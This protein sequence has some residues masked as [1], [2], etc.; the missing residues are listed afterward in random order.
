MKIDNL[1]NNPE[2]DKFK[3]M[4]DIK[5]GKE[6]ITKLL[7]GLKVDKAAGP[8]LIKPILLNELHQELAP[9]LQ[10]LF[11]LSLDTGKL[12]SDWLDS[13]PVKEEKGEEMYYD[14][15]AVFSPRQSR[16]G[17]YD[18]LVMSSGVFPDTDSG[19]SSSYKSKL[20]SS[21]DFTQSPQISPGALVRS[22]SL[23]RLNAPFV[24]QEM[25]PFQTTFRMD[26]SI[27]NL[28][29]NLEDS[30][31]RRCVLM[32]KLKEA[33]DTLELQSERLSKIETAAKG[34]TI[35]VEDLRLKER[36]YRRKIDALHLT[37]QE[38]EMLKME[39][40]K[41][42][43]DMQDRIDKLDFALRS[44]QAQHQVTENE[45]QKRIVLLEQTGQALSMLENENT[46]LQQDRESMRQ[47]MAVAKEAIT[48]ARSKF[49][50]MEEENKDLR[51]QVMRL[52]EENAELTK[53]VAELSGQ[54]ME[55]RK[56]TSSMKD[57]N[58]KLAS[59]WK[60]LAEEKQKMSRQL[61]ASQEKASDLKS[62]AS[63]AAVE[64]DRLFHEK[65]DLN[66]KYQ[67]LLVTKEQL[68]RKSCVLE[69]QMRDAE[70]ELTRAKQVSQKR[71]EEK[72]RIEEEVHDL[73]KA[74]QDLSSEL[75]SVKAYYE[76]ALEQIGTLENG[77]KVQQQQHDWAT[78]EQE[79]LKAEVDRLGKVAEGK[80]KELKREKEE[81][82]ETV[83]GMKSE[84][85]NM[86][87]EKN[88]M[89]D[90]IEELE[91]KLHKA[92]D[93]LKYSATVSQEELDTWKDTCD[94]LTA[95][96][97]RKESEIQA[98]S[99]KCLDLEDMTAKLQGE[100]R[101]LKEDCEQ[102]TDKQEDVN[103]MKEENRKL[104]REKA[105]N[106]QMIKLLETQKEVLTK[107][108]ENQL[109]KLHDVEQLTSKVEQFRN[110]NEHLRERVLELEKVRDNLVNQKEE[111]LASTE[112][113][114]KKPKLE[115]L[116]KKVEELREANRQLRDIND[117]VNEKCESLEQENLELKE[118]VGGD[119]TVV[120]KYD[121][122]RVREEKVHL[123]DELGQ[124]RRELD[125]LRQRHEQYVEDYGPDGEEILKERN[126]VNRLER[127]KEGLEKQVA[128]INGQLLLVEGSKKR[129]DEVVED[130]QQEIVHLRKE[131][132][133]AEKQPATGPELDQLQT[134]VE[135]LRSELTRSQKEKIKQ[136][137]LV[138]TL[139]EELDEERNKKPTKIRESLDDVGT[140]LSEM[141]GELHKLVGVIQS[142]DQAIE[143]LENQLRQSKE[144]IEDKD[145]A[146]LELKNIMKDS[147][148]SESAHS[149]EEPLTRS[150]LHKDNYIAYVA[151][152]RK[153]VL[154]FLKDP[155]ESNLIKRLKPAESNV[156]MQRSQE[157]SGSES[158]LT[159]PSV[160]PGLYGAKYV[161]SKP[162]RTQS[163]TE[164]GSG[165]RLQSLISKY[166]S[167]GDNGSQ[168]P[169]RK[170][171]PLSLS[172]SNKM[173]LVTRGRSFG[174]AAPKGNEKDSK[175]SEEKDNDLDVTSPL[176]PTTPP[177]PL[178]TVTS[179]HGE[180]P[181][182]VSSPTPPA[183]SSEG[184]PMT[185]EGHPM[186]SEGHS[187]TSVDKQNRHGD[188]V[189]V[190]GEY[191]EDDGAYGDLDDDDLDTQEQRDINSLIQK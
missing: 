91:T 152:Y 175:V 149:A 143:T 168:V 84:L 18:S 147:K 26:R 121:L 44:L 27:R 59:S 86:K 106:E 189:A 66:N 80:T 167:Y 165:D 31:N 52:K 178:V 160:T 33:Q 35:L 73:R 92:N 179:P 68:D 107:S 24:A 17:V 90:K 157:L 119:G 87:N 19:F 146:M 125:G 123:E 88:L 134:E 114:Y 56:L 120:P 7:K 41:L 57:E 166:R 126:R 13:A 98:L 182:A 39:N 117:T 102:L 115:E 170:I 138:K 133:E 69:E 191:D 81:M 127:E 164:K 104:L 116:E 180:G 77:K 141:R 161:G 4:P 3:T 159:K 12:P 1:N 46:R 51:V 65:M 93:D 89:E 122:E 142:K 63:S 148:G 61:E 131:L 111:L 49:E 96:V 78:Q 128:L 48:L 162:Q 83:Q 54:L 2:L 112:L 101:A 132:E 155:K 62:K 171:K 6:G 75:S 11:Q 139:K 190:S 29:D 163:L 42:R 37:E 140:E 36:D 32:H 130:L 100:N 8:D 177:P 169:E 99:E 50:P 64:K 187:M 103:K 20:Q 38:K 172:P 72:G 21:D 186:T 184:R 5:V 151:I 108:S 25:T 110:E 10:I 181:L 76:R 145:K 150:C 113:I 118:A 174:P 183:Q 153:E 185:S 58:E 53:K 129:L 40:I 136:E 67:Q 47:E 45:N 158:D 95:S 176:L 137:H 85:R 74:N 55:L 30:E 144:K 9:I 14:S 79:R 188:R 124:V 34:N 43:Q 70:A 82:E 173:G 22:R 28:R 156:Q 94:R 109:A 23:S 97:S 135:D 71:E 60:T 105:E 15:P 154:K 16:A